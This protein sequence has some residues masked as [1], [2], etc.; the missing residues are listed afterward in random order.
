MNILYLS[1]LGDDLA[2]GPTY[3][4]PKQIEAQSKIDN[5]FWYNAV[6]KGL[7]EWRELT[8]YHD[9]REFPNE[10]IAD[11]PAPFN[12]PDIVVVE[13]FYNMVK[14]KFIWELLRSNL[15]YVI[16]PRGELTHQAQL[17]KHIKKLAT[18]LLVTYRYAKKAKAIQY[19]TE[20]ERQDSG[21]KWNETQIIV[22][23]GIDI[24]ELKANES[25]IGDSIECVSIGRI[26]PYQKGLDMLIEACVH[27][28]DTLKQNN[29]HISIYGPDREN[30]AEGLQNEIIQNGLED[31]ISIHGPVYGNEKKNI[32]LSS[33]VFLMPSRFEGHPMALIEA[34]SYGLPCIATTGSNMKKEVEEYDAGWTAECSADSIVESICHMIK[35][36]SQVS[37]KSIQAQKLAENYRWDVIANVTHNKY[38]ELLR[39]YRGHTGE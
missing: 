22:P 2:A 30:K 17:R 4:V 19:L 18:N 38:C 12:K 3:S 10:T 6:D 29:V 27:L 24:P 31:I 16:I 9:K 35:E 34:L 32:L 1:H 26:E 15:P 37:M 21:S 23:N 20:Q 14:S 11:L 7:S 36:K 39:N 28:R 33:N 5:V 13:L 25:F 8:Y